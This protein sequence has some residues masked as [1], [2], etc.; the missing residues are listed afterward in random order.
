MS[1]FVA[2]PT[3]VAAMHGAAILIHSASNHLFQTAK[4][5]AY[6]VSRLP[7][8]NNRDRKSTAALWAFSLH[9]APP[10]RDRSCHSTEIH[11]AQ[12]P[13][14]APTPSPGR[15]LAGR[16]AQLPRRLTLA[17]PFYAGS[18][19]NGSR[20]VMPTSPRVTLRPPRDA[21]AA[22]LTRPPGAGYPR[23]G[24]LPLRDLAC[25]FHGCGVRFL[26]SQRHSQ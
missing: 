5:V 1:A 20:P 8:I 13:R 12:R 6:T 17:G 22:T 14:L 16:P 9:G 23:G 15:P 18:W 3:M 24:V 19:S 26:P 21:T 4:V 7:G 2:M 10:M 11:V 25:A